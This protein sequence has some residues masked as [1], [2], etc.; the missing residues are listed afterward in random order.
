M[1]LDRSFFACFMA[2]RDLIGVFVSFEYRG[3]VSTC[4]TPRR[5]QRG[6]TRRLCRLFVSAACYVSVIYLFTSPTD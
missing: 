3:V 1:H 4:L 6:E 5:L 2:Y